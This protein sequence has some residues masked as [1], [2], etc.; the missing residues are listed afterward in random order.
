MKTLFFPVLLFILVLTVSCVKHGKREE[1]HSPDSLSFTYKKLF[2]S[3]QNCHPDSSLCAYI[4]Y[5][6]PEFENLSGPLKDSLPG[7]FS[8]FWSW[9]ENES[10]QPDSVVKKFIADY[11]T[12]SKEAKENPIPW[13]VEKTIRVNNQ[14][15]K[16]IS[17][18][19]NDFGFTGGAHSNGSVKFLM[20]EKETGKRL[21]LQDFFDSTGLKKLTRIGEKYFREARELKDQE[22]L[23]E[24][25]FWF[26][27][28][29]FELPQN[30]IFSENGI[31]FVFNPYE[32]GPFSL[33]STKF[34]IPA[35][36]F[37]KFMK[38]NSPRH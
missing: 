9:K 10:S 28:N 12:Y 19:F 34:E 26:K 15:N 35:P 24:E 17:L 16:W 37:V 18:T 14:N 4:Q 1:S 23:E 6:Y 3:Y 7:H 5:E 31:L 22:T 30:F 21:T 27:N 11:E 38:V 13:E 2:K 20:L 25:G 33:G 36:Q 29:L 32:V 8:R